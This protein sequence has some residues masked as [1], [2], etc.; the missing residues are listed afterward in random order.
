MSELK[1][2]TDWIIAVYLLLLEEDELP[3]S[4][5][6]ML[7]V[8]QD[9]E[10]CPHSEAALTLADGASMA[11]RF[12]NHCGFDWGKVTLQ[13]LKPFAVQSEVESARKLVDSARQERDE[14][15][16]WVVDVKRILKRRNVEFTLADAAAMLDNSSIVDK[17]NDIVQMSADTFSKDLARLFGLTWSQIEEVDVH[18]KAGFEIINDSA[19]C[20]AATKVPKSERNFVLRDHTLCVIS[21]KNPNTR[22]CAHC[23]NEALFMPDL[24]DHVAWAAWQQDHMRCLS[25]RY[26]VPVSTTATDQGNDEKYHYFRDCF[27]VPSKSYSI[28]EIFAMLPDL[29]ASEAK[30]MQDSQN[31]DSDDAILAE[32]EAAYENSELKKMDDEFAKSSGGK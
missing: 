24:D 19:H 23:Q 17:D 6:K 22:I 32:F 25:H 14:W 18:D 13:E 8:A 2:L 10:F 28:E 16:K 5:D 21:T 27:F 4:A 20:A 30:E 1:N 7:A 3:K 26:C 9:P 12:K 11:T 31:Y 15:V 29:E